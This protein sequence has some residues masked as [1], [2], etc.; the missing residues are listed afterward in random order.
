MGGAARFENDLLE[1]LQQIG[2]SEPFCNY[3][4][5]YVAYARRQQQC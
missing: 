1:V 2:G 4:S 3:V 5:I